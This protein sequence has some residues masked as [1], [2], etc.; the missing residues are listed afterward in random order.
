M[1]HSEV[2]QKLRYVFEECTAHALGLKSGSEDKGNTFF[3]E[4][5][6]LLHVTSQQRIYCITTAAITSNFT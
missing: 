6:K 5:D 2:S 4:L 3:K 1:W